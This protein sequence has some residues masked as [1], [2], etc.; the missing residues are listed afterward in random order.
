MRIRSRCNA[1]QTN[2]EDLYVGVCVTR[3][4]SAASNQTSSASSPHR[5]PQMLPMA[6]P[7]MLTLGRATIQ[8]KKRQMQQRLTNDGVDS[9]RSALR[10]GGK[11]A[12]PISAHPLKG[13]DA[14]RSARNLSLHKCRADLMRALVSTSGT[15][16]AQGLGRSARAAAQLR[17]RAITTSSQRR[18]SSSA[19]GNI[20]GLGWLGGASLEVEEEAAPSTSPSKPWLQQLATHTAAGPL[21]PLPTPLP[22]R[23]SHHALARPPDCLPS[24]NESLTVPPT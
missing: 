12:C 21:S 11:C 18:S 14:M 19:T 23:Y 10:S 3:E 20:G 24:T 5:E 13:V 7:C 6:H 16:H 1:P 9:L 17:G 15:L 8:H 22:P 2:A 4:A